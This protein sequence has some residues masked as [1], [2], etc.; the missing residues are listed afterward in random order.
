MTIDMPHSQLTHSLASSPQTVCLATSWC[1][2]CVMREFKCERSAKTKTSHNSLIDN[3]ILKS[4]VFDNKIILS[5]LTEH[6]VLFS[7]VCIFGSNI[8]NRSFVRTNTPLWTTNI[9]EK[10]NMLALQYSKAVINDYFH[11]WFICW[12]FSWSIDKQ[13]LSSYNRAPNVLSQTCFFCPTNGPK[14]PKSF[15]EYAFFAT[16]I[17]CNMFKLSPTYFWIF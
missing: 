2:G 9:P 3:C 14:P 5:S 16:N 17:W 8:H 1:P 13:W 15:D 11:Y 10:I 12:L 6:T 7:L 4:N